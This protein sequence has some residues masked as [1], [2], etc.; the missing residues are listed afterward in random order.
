MTL[1]PIS[2][3]PGRWLATLALGAL[4]WGACAGSG[5]DTEDAAP[6]E[7][8]ETPEAPPAAPDA[9]PVGGLLNPNLA[10]EDELASLPGMTSP[11]VRAIQDGRPFLDMRTLDAALAP[12]LDAPAR[13]ELYRRLWVPIDLN[14][15]PREEILLIPGV[16]D[17]M[18]HEFEEYRPYDSMARFRREIGKYVD[19][20]EV[21]RLAR[22]VFVP[23]DLNTAT[24]EEI[25]AI[26]GVGDRMVH[27]F[28]EYRP[29]E[30]MEEFM[31]EI[32]KYVDDD[33]LARLARYVTIR[34]G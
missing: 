25:L 3:R 5:A 12:H 32:G 18:A 7:A 4:V 26:P 34:G 11:T 24:E 29:Y 8:A 15:A 21:E 19:E 9:R 14:A 10:G 6:A 23:I 31:R 33:E 27:E 2:P 17:R 13:E 30:G 28:M 20:E 1:D 22:Y 16:G